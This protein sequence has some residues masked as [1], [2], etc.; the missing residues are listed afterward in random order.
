[1][2]GSLLEQPSEH[3]LPREEAVSEDDLKFILT[4]LEKMPG[5]DF[6]RRF[7]NAEKMERDNQYPE[8]KKLYLK[9][10][11]ICIQELQNLGQKGVAEMLL[12]RLN[13]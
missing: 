13:G 2:S 11:E 6:V 10:K 12:K 3:P 5:E 8:N 7:I 9:E 1:M 4:S